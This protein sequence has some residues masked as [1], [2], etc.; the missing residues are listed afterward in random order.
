MMC[1]VC[2]VVCNV[3]PNSRYKLDKF[4]DEYAYTSRKE[5]TTRRRHMILQ[6]TSL[7][8]M[9]IEDNTLGFK[10]SIEPHSQCH[11]SC[12][13]RCR[14]SWYPHL[15]HGRAKPSKRRT[16][17]PIVAGATRRI[18]SNRYCKISDDSSVMPKG[19]LMPGGILCGEMAATPCTKAIVRSRLPTCQRP[20]R[21]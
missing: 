5:M 17:M 15:D 11:V 6:K 18:F 8:R 13:I 4:E 2:S 1:S 12:V 19:T 14:H 20:A 3:L 7:H 16:P 10:H 9:F 21:Q